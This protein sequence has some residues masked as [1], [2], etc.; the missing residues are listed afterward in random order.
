[1]ALE[2]YTL[3]TV[4]ING[5]VL[6]EE[7][8]VTIDRR[9]NA[10]QVN[11]VAKGYAGDSPGAAMMTISVDNAVP[12]EDFEFD[13]GPYML[14]LK[15]VEIKIFAAGRSLKTDGRITDDNFSHAVDS[16]SNLRFDARC[17]FANWE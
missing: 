1:M 9:S 8:R 6:S 4:V 15:P 7:A 3:A 12:S 16:N 2:I 17:K 5:A 13:P 14:T 10:Q 11:T